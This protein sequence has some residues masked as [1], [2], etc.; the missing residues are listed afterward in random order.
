MMRGFLAALMILV[1]ALF[2]C[3]VGCGGGMSQEAA[4]EQVEVSDAQTDMEAEEAE[5]AAREFMPSA[6][7][8]AG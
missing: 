4:R 7:E 3:L 6:T 8:E 5:E 1:L 2:H